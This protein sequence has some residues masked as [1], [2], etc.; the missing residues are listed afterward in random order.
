MLSWGEPRAFWFAVVIIPIIFFYFLR[1]RFRRQ[2]VSSI[3]IWSRLQMT[4][5]GGRKL[6]YWSVLLL[7]IQVL[8]A[9]AGVVTLARPA[10]VAQR[11]EQ[12]GIVY[13]LDVSASM[14]AQDVEGGRLAQAKSILRRGG[15]FPLIPRS[16]SIW[17]GLR[18]HTMP[19]TVHQAL[20][21]ALKAVDAY[22]AVLMKK[23]RLRS[24]RP[25][26]TEHRPGKWAC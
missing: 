25:G 6:R 8:A 9:T 17:L 10:W 4:S 12:P 20:L 15:E 16:S 22:M 1:M 23:K 18:Q 21:S 11:L 19:S 24:Y 26:M 14:N 3:Y 2:P 7:L 13:I 5:R